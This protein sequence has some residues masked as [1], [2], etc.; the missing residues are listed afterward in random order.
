MSLISRVPPHASDLVSSYVLQET[1]QLE[2]LLQEIEHSLHTSARS[3]LIARSPELL[4]MVYQV[5]KK[6]MASFVT[7]PVPAD[8]Q[9]YCQRFQR[10]K[11]D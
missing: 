8:F 3:E 7:A 2:S 11:V 4:N 9:R 1:E 6:P 10:S 5:H